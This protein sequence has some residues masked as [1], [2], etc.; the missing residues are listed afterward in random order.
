MK[1]SLK[2][3]VYTLFKSSFIK[4]SVSFQNNAPDGEK[5]GRRGNC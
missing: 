2:S 1:S 4:R 5:K 3:P